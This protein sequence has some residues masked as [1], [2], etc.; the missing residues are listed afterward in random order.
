M[1]GLTKREQRWKADQRAAETLAGVVKAALHAATQVAA[2]E[3]QVT[4]LEALRAENA[5]L[6]A[7]VAKW[8][9]LAE[10]FENTCNSAIG[11][12]RIL[13]DLCAAQQPLG[14]EFEAVWDAAEGE[15]YEK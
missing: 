12:R 14:A 9:A 8:Q 11:N 2:S 10:G 13:A 4:E 5:R 3:V 1:F 7:D 6:R 15:L